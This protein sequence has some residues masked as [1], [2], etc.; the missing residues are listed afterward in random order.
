MQ[1]TAADEQGRHVAFKA[2]GWVLRRLF[3][4]KDNYFGGYTQFRTMQEFLERFDHDPNLVGDPVEQKYRPGR[5]S[6]GGLTAQIKADLIS[7]IRTPFK[8]P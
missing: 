5:V 7:R 3:C 2:L 4:V 1:S 6:V 8:L